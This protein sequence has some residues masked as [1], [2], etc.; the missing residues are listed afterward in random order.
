MCTVYV[1]SILPD[2]TDFSVMASQSPQLFFQQLVQADDKVDIRAPQYLLFVGESTGCVTTPALKQKFCNFGDI[3]ITGT[4]SCQ[5]GN[6][7]G[8]E[9]IIKIIF[10]Y[11]CSLDWYGRWVRSHMHICARAS[12]ATAMTL[13]IHMGLGA[14]WSSWPMDY[15]YSIM[16]RDHYLETAGCHMVIC[17][18]DRELWWSVSWGLDDNGFIAWHTLWKWRWWVRSKVKMKKWK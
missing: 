16:S 18:R 2:V 9:N 10:L 4:G 12:V 11:Q 7:T 1:K 17:H 8:D 15:T 13:T 5:N 6:T 14:P 3:F